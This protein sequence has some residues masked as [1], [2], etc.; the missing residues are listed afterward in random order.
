MAKTPSFPIL[1]DYTFKIEI[2]DLKKWEHFKTNKISSICFSWANERLKVQLESHTLRPEPFIEL[3]YWYNRQ[4]VYYQVKLVSVPSNLG[5]GKVWFFC[6]P[7]TNKKC[8]KLYFIGGYFLHREAFQDAMYEKQ[9]ESKAY[10]ELEKTYGSVFKIEELQEQI[11]SK[12]FKTHYA[13]K[14]TK[15]YLKLLEKIEKNRQYL[16]EFKFDS[17]L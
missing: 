11:H 7:I 12:Y 9:T 2:A 4:K 6:C 5:I 8:R 1:Y 14:P 16:D 17:K 3:S 15:R 13:G 10:R